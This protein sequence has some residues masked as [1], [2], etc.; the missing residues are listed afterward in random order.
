[1]SSNTEFLNTLAKQTVE[2]SDESDNNVSDTEVDLN[3]LVNESDEN[4]SEIDIQ[5]QFSSHSDT[6]ASSAQN[7]Q[8]NADI[9]NAINAQILEQLDRLG[10]RLDSMEKNQHKKTA[11]KSKIKST[12]K[13]KEKIPAAN[14]ATVATEQVRSNSSNLP[15]NI[16]ALRQDAL[17]QAQVK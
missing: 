7:T 11:D 6:T 4:N 2:M 16:Q 5:A 12:A 10:K 8:L 15:A 17:V 13:S 9:Q 14:V 3:H 1:M